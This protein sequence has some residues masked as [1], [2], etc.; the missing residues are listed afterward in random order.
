MNARRQSGRNLAITAA[1]TSGAGV[2]G[3]T[4]TGPTSIV[5]TASHERFVIKS[6][7]A[8]VYNQANLVVKVPQVRPTLKVQSALALS[9]LI[10]LLTGCSSSASP[11]AAPPSVSPAAT[12][13][14]SASPA[15][16]ASA[17]PSPRPSTPAE[18]L[19]AAKFTADEFGAP[20]ELPLISDHASTVAMLSTCRGGLWSVA[21]GRKTAGW[22]RQWDD[23]VNHIGGGQRI[24][25]LPTANAA[26]KQTLFAR[27]A[28]S[29]A[30][31]S[32]TNF[33]GT[34]IRRYAYPATVS[35]VY[36][37]CERYIPTDAPTSYECTAIMGRGRVLMEII[38][39]APDL[40][41]ARDMLQLLLV[42]AQ[43]HL[44]MA[45]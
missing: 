36:T 1:V 4:V 19:E 14:A 41:H 27:Q 34:K 35:G 10:A 16:S 43:Q 3:A 29:A 7:P 30:C 44:A 45:A 28:A 23:D 2:P 20:T 40:G 37:H 12:P 33:E 5:D 11:Q 6:C 9:V 17:A 25:V 31:A 8:S 26:A 22:I 24:F 15:A 32:Y 38:G 13:S 18:M 39:W 21:D 42:P